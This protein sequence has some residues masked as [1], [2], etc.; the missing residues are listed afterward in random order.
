MNCGVASGSPFMYGEYVNVSVIGPVAAVAVTP[1]GFVNATWLTRPVRPDSGC[2]ECPVLHTQPGGR[3]VDHLAWFGP[4]LVGG[5]HHR[6]KSLIVGS[7]GS[8]VKEI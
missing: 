8:M 3:L 2:V 7:P 5:S 6:W 4:G 1:A